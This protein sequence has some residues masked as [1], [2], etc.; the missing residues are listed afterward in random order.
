MEDDVA[1]DSK[2]DPFAKLCRTCPCG[3]P[4]VVQK[5]M[6]KIDLD[7]TNTGAR[8]TEGRCVRQVLKVADA[9]EVR[10]QYT[11][12]RSLVGSAITVATDMSKDRTDIQAGSTANT[13]EDFALFCVGQ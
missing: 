5:M 12:N 13:V 7:R 9:P 11:P 10:C 4:T 3:I 8:T 6:M 2:H 1:P